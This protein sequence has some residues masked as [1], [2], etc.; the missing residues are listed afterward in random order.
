MILGGGPE[1]KIRGAGAKISGG[2]KPFFFFGP[3]GLGPPQPSTWVR[4]WRL[5]NF[6]TTAAIIRYIKLYSNTCKSRDQLTSSFENQNP[7]FSPQI[8]DKNR[9]FEGAIVGIKPTIAPQNIFFCYLVHEGPIFQPIFYK[10]IVFGCFGLKSI[11][12]LGQE[13][14]SGPYNWRRLWQS[15]APS[16]PR[17]N[18][19]NYKVH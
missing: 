5:A 15:I 14:K 10:F 2:P 16:E 6:E 12:P 4:P 7:T 8:R 11:Y 1:L 18:S 19:S 9:D 17:N 13:S 3:G